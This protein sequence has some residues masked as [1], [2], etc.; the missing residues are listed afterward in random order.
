MKSLFN[1]KKNT[2]INKKLKHE[3]LNSLSWSGSSPKTD[4]II[5]IVGILIILIILLSWSWRT[6]VSVESGAY[7]DTSVNSE[8][9][10]S[11]EIVDEE[12]LEKIVEKF[13][14]REKIFKELT[15]GMVLSGSSSNETENAVGTTTVEEKVE[16]L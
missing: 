5:S 2:R 3:R 10:N 6:F 16:D 15:G 11:K 1:K 12:R 9:N 13:E 14:K 8:L 4:W 7:L